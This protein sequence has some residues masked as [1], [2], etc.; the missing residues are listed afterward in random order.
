MTVD[1]DNTFKNIPDGKPVRVFLPLRNTHDRLR[2]Q[3][4]CQEIAPPKFSLVFSPGALPIEDIDS[5]QTAI[6]SIDMGGP[7]LSLEAK[8]Q[9]IDGPQILKMVLQKTISHKQLREFFRIDAATSVTATALRPAADGAP[10]WSVQGESLDISGSGVLVLFPQCPPED[11]QVKLSIFLPTADEQ[12]LAAIGHTV[13][14]QRQD[15]GRCEVAYHFD[16]ISIEDR[17]KIIGHC[18]VLQRKMLRL[19]VQVLDK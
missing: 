8:I 7:T 17:D 3:C 2:L 12:P 5:K 19:K 13:R 11:K 1:L 15:D 16:D 14:V 18:L 9:E 10:P 6:I 4:V